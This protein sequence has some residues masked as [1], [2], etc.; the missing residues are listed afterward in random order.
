MASRLRRAKDKEEIYK[1]LVNE[2]DSPFLQFSHVFIM[3]ACVG[4]LYGKCPDLSSMGEQI[5][6]SVFSDD[7]DQAIVNA[8]AFASTSDLRLLL[9]TEKQMD[10]KFELIE[11][12]ANGGITILKEK[13]LDAPGKPIDNLINLIFE[14]DQSNN[15]KSNIMDIAEDLF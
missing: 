13:I 11:K 1:R 2:E 5:P 6:W 7:A 3:A 14:L 10:L 15:T 12:F 8:I 4:H 9:S